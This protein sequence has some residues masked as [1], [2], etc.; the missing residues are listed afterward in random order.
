[1]K[2]AFHP[3][4]LAEYEDAARYYASCQ[5]G[6]EHRFITAVEYAIAQIVATPERWPLLDDVIRRYLTRVFPYAVLYSIE[7]DYLLILAVMHSHRKPGYW[8]DRVGA[9]VEK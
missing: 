9:P 2:F 8:R 1:M 7:Q 5:I 3:E 4:A 6:L